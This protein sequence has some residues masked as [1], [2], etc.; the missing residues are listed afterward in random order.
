MGDLLVS[1]VNVLSDL[2]SLSVHMLIHAETVDRS[3]CSAFGKQHSPQKTNGHHKNL[4]ISNIF[5]LNVNNGNP[6]NAVLESECEW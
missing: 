5:R 6:L 2:P 3:K 4:I 1:G